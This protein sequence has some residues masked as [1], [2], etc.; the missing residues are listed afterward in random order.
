MGLG[1]PHQSHALQRQHPLIVPRP[2]HTHRTV[3]AAVYA[4]REGPWPL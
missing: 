3:E 2:R 1:P 4:L